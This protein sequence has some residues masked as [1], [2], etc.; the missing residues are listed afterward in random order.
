MKIP[1]NVIL[2]MVGAEEV[3]VADGVIIIRRYDI[4][5]DELVEMRYDESGAKILFDE[6]LQP[7]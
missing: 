3:E 7:S 5:T 4:A 1:K 6:P 2:L